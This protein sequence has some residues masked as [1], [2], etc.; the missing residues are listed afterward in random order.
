MGNVLLTCAGRRN[1]LVG[2]FREA[3]AGRGRVLVADASPYAPAMQEADQSFTVPPV[4]SPDYMPTLLGLCRQQ[5]VGLLISLNDLELPSLARHRDDFLS[6]GVFPVVASPEV[7]DLCFDKWATAAFLARLGLT[8]PRSFLALG[9]CREAL[10]RGEISFPLIVKPRWGTAS[11]GVERPADW[12]ELEWVW[13]MGHHRLARSPLARLSRDRNDC[14]LIQEHLPGEE[15]GLDIVNDL[16][17]NYVATWVRRKLAMRAGETDQAETVSHPL[18]EAVGA[19]LA[20]TLR[21]PGILDCD[22]FL[23]GEDCRVLEINP[24]FGGGYPFSHAAGA[25]LPSAL[26]AWSRGE[27]PA[28]NWLQVRPGVIS[29]KCDRLVKVS[30]A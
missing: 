9:A 2:Y 17:G 14:L 29:A 11:I 26:I 8:A 12:E 28:P 23:H 21:Q 18:L 10:D 5:Q 6:C 13:R 3:L 19:Q 16:D 22:V 30:V 1:Y 24:R 4:H 20:R 7:V 15:Y 27:T 25:D